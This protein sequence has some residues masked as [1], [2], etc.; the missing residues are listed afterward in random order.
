MGY[1]AGLNL[2]IIPGGKNM[3]HTSIYIYMYMQCQCTCMT[4]LQDK[5]LEPNQ[6][7]LY[8]KQ[9]CYICLYRQQTGSTTPLKHSGDYYSLFSHSGTCN[10]NNIHKFSF[11]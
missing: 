6:K 10:F 1:L 9:R 3:R 11:T 5:I 2:M 7:R 4:N 8:L